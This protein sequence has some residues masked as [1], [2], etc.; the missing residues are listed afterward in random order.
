M[1][2][3]PVDRSL[4]SSIDADGYRNTL[5]EMN[6][7]FER[8]SRYITN[9]ESDIQSIQSFMNELQRQEAQ[10]INVGESVES[11]NFQKFQLDT[12]LQWFSDQRRMYINKL[13]KDLYKFTRDIAEAASQIENRSGGE[14][15]EDLIARKMVGVRE[16]GEDANYTMG[17]VFGLVGLCERCLLELAS[18]IAELGPVIENAKTK[19]SRGFNVGN[20]IVEIETQK[21]KLESDFRSNILRIES[22]LGSNKSY[23][24]KCLKRIE[25]VADEIKSKEEQEAEDAAAAAAA[26]EAAE[27][28]ATE[29]AED[30]AE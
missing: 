23:S 21:V 27:S 14:S 8:M 16:F 28:D 12:D 9:L 11:L 18:D 13:F 4:A 17:D 30:S 3:T 10:G 7:N 19:Q 26:E 2:I 29:V 5:N 24:A 20:L 15:D 25:L 1:N 6:E 22:F